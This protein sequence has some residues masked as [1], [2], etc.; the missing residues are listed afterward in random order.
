MGDLVP[1]WRTAAS[2]FRWDR[3]SNYCQ[4][5]GFAKQHRFRAGHLCQRQLESKTGFGSLVLVNPIGVQRVVT[6]TGGR[7][8]EWLPEIVATKKP[9]EAAACSTVPSHIAG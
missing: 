1:G 3:R 5:L 6:A 9:L 4:S 7:I 8:V 2:R